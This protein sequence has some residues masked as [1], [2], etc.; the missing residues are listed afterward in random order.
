[1]A[2]CLWGAVI[3]PEGRLPEPR[4]YRT[5]GLWDFAAPA[6]NH[7]VRKRHFH[8]Y[9]FREQV[10]K[11][12]KIAKFAPKKTLKFSQPPETFRQEILSSSPQVLGA[13]VI[14]VQI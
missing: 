1:M 9:Q 5:Y 11:V 2:C 7:A 13:L 8:P 3:W 12:A 6:V 14:S 4:P 10:A